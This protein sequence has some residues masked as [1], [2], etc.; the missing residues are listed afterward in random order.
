LISPQITA[1]APVMRTSIAV[2]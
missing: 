1:P 2:I